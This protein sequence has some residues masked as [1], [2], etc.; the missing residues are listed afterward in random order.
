MA[1]RRNSS[2]SPR[3]KRR[4]SGNSS[5]RFLYIGIGIFAI[6][7]IA[8]GIWFITGTD[9]DYKFQRKQLDKYVEVTNETNLLEDGAAVY[10]DLSDGMLSAYA[11]PDSKAL[12]QSIIDKLA[13]NRAIEFYGLG[14]ERIFELKKS[15]TEL[16]NFLLNPNSYNLQKAPI[17]KTLAQIVTNRQPALLMSDFEEYK[18]SVIEKAA[19]AKR[20]FIDWLALGYNITFY[21]WEFAEKGHQKLMF[22]AVFDDNANRLNSL[23]QS[24][25]TL[26]DPNIERYVLGG[27]DFAF[28]TSTLYPSFKQGGNY[29]NGNGKDIVTAVTEDGGPESYFCYA[30][31]Y[32]TANGVPG[33]FA[34]LNIS[35]GTLAEFYPLGVTYEHA[36]QNAK[37]MKEAGVPQE[38]LYTHLL[39]NLFVDFGAQ[40][41]YAINNI[42]ARVFDLQSAMKAIYD[43]GDSITAERLD[44]IDMP[45]INMV[46][47]ASIEGAEDLPAGWKEILVDFDEKFDG[48]F[49]GGIPSSNLIRANVVIS[50]VSPKIDQAISFF[51][52]PD[53]PSLANSVKETLTSASS[54]PQGRI[55]YTYYIKSK[56][57]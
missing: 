41:G 39:S 16:Y 54:S 37:K 12:L 34:P 23:V 13:A 17:E 27:H 15:H 22:L 28:P 26:T 40:D 52:W 2:A 11:T 21:K 36:I 46:L 42:E 20:A 3:N 53:N 51:S 48:T 19:Y 35:L 5:S 43:I 6:A 4:K 1:R 44:T 7:T 49:M 18:G 14:D 29:H 9:S 24:A 8:V 38:S 47:T 57:E 31:P 56:S 33:Q 25:V 45:E 32:A 10:L 30:K 55:L 50:D